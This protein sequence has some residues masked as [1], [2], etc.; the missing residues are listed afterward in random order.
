MR[1]RKYK[2]N[3]C[4][5]V[6]L[7]FPS[8]TSLLGTVSLLLLIL[9]RLIL[10]AETMLKTK[11]CFSDQNYCTLFVFDF[12][13]LFVI[14]CSYFLNLNL[15]DPVIYKYFL[16]KLRHLRSYHIQMILYK[17]YKQKSQL[18]WQKVCF[19]LQM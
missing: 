4:D 3:I 11:I 13:C 14:F 7:L 16:L 15:D 19:L 2:I 8:N 1:K 9:P 6:Y 17:Y 18:T 5:I 12:V 10:W